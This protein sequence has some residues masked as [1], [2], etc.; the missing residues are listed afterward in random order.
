MPAAPQDIMLPLAL[1]GYLILQFTIAWIASRTIK[2]EADYFLAG[3]KLGVFAIAMSVFATWFGAE[4][5]M[6]SSGAV[7]AECLAGGRADPIGYTICLLAMATF[8]A[9]KMREAGVVTFVDF[10]RERFGDTANWLA[11]LLTIPT[12]VVW[13]S[14]QLLAMGQIIADVTS[15]EFHWG[16]GGGAST[17]ISALRAR[18]TSP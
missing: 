8:I 1:V 10:F 18:S 3:R 4:S 13:A 14:A 5:V 12:S 9:Y 6:G 15:L 16:L 17:H 2:V 7:A 11:A